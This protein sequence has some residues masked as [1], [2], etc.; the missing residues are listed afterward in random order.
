[1]TRS[2]SPPTRPPEPD[3]PKQVSRFEFNLL[4]VLRF[5]LGHHPSD[6][7]LQ[8]IRAL[9]HRPPCLSS[10]AI[11]LAKDSL[12]KGCVLYLVRAGGWRNDRFLRDGTPNRGRV[13]ERSPLEDRTLH[14]SHHVLDFLMWATAERLHD[15]QQS[16]DAPP[17]GL[18]PADELFFWLAFEA[19]R[20]DPDLTQVLRRKAAFRSNPLCWLA[21][22]G[23]ITEGTD[24]APPNFDACFTGLRA[25]I[26]ECLQPELARRW[27]RSE[28]S[29]GQIGDWAA[30]REQGRAEF[31]ALNGFLE[32]AARA[33]RLDLA[34][35]VLSVNASLFRNALEPAFWTGGLQGTGPSRLADRLDTQRA[36]LAV[37]R[38]MDT[39]RAWDEQAR[40]VGY[41]DGGYAASQMYKQEW[42]AAD[43][44]RIADRARAAVAAI[45]PLRTSE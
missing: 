15:T 11:H 21:F 1:M 41:F 3:G 37:P 38:L 18:M 35:F 28:R 26:L 44:D 7:G 43:G 8:L 20:T 22:P 40:S 13:W 31:A 5:L 4:N 34:R 19:C 29:K 12:S 16:W 45:E 42:E 6:R 36:A 10:T 24:P 32:A 25:A 30:M 39:L 17:D 9:A 23:D 33:N 14:F 2:A 27:V